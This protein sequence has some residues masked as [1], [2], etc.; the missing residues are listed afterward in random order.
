MALCVRSV[1][2]ALP[3]PRRACQTAS[4]HS[5]RNWEMMPR[6]S[7]SPSCLSKPVLIGSYWPKALGNQENDRPRQKS[8]SWPDRRRRQHRSVIISDRGNSYKKRQAA[9]T[10]RSNSE[11]TMLLQPWCGGRLPGAGASCPARAG[12]ES[13]VGGKLHEAGTTG[14]VLQTTALV[15]EAHLRLIDR[16]GVSWPDRARFL[17]VAARIVPADAG[18][19]CMQ[20]PACRSR[21]ED[22]GECE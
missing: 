11:V 18:A 15:N 3:H 10:M 7:L 9:R 14:H 5:L 19:L 6:L 16:K 8:L 20:A 12:G 1:L 13:P 17:G 22:N 21:A 4:W 2:R